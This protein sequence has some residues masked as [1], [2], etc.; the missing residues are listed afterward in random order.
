MLEMELIHIRIAGIGK[1]PIAFRVGRTFM[2][3]SFI[4]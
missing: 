3:K 1:S 2:I 4:C